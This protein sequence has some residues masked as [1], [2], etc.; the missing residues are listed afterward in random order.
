MSG[1]LGCLH[2]HVWKYRTRSIALYALVISGTIAYIR[3]PFVHTAKRVPQ[4][5]YL[6]FISSFTGTLI[7]LYSRSYFPSEK[8]LLIV[9]MLLIASGSLLNGFF[10]MHLLS[11]S[12]TIKS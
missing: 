5:G 1:L 8:W 4:Q 2:E 3:G 6:P 12:R 10:R 11:G 9:G 7:I